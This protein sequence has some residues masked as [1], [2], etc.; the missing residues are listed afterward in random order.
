[1]SGP[2]LAWAVETLIASALLMAAVLLARGPARRAFGPQVA[3][4]LWALPALR[5]LLPP[6][7]SEVAEQV[8]MPIS[9]ASELMLVLPT[10]VPGEAAPADIPWAAIALAFWA[11]GAGAFFVLHL[12]RHRAFCRR[13]LAD[14]RVLDEVDGVRVIESD[15]ASGPLAFGMRRRFVAFPRDFAERYDAEE[16]ELALLHE[17]GH[18]QRRDL[19]ANWAA[20]AVLALHWFNP[21]AWRAFRAFRCDQE[22]A[23]DARV[24]AGRGRADRHI[25]ACAIVKAAHGGHV[26][27]ACHLH[28]IADLKGRLRM[29]T[30]ATP[31]RRRLAAGATAVVGV[32]AAGLCV[33]ASGTRAAAAVTERIGDAVGV[34]LAQVAPAVPAAPVVPTPPVAPSVVTAPRTG[35]AK[36]IHRVVVSKDGETHVYE[37]DD[38]KKYLA[39]NPLPQPPIPP[40][41]VAGAAR[42]AAATPPMPPMP[43]TFR[44]VGPTR[45]RVA[46]DGRTWRSIAPGPDGT[47]RIT[48]P[49]IIN[50]PCDDG[51][52]GDAQSLVLQREL[53]GRKVTIVCQNRVDRAARDGARRGQE[54]AAD[55]RFRGDVARLAARDA[56]HDAQLSIQAARSAILADRNLSGSQRRDALAGLNQ[57]QAELRSSKD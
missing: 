33:T 40:V 39:A 49:E 20:L 56:R 12:L 10:A 5:L 19:W 2:T 44:M 34:D 9:R 53:N 45:L 8:E 15:A 31:S 28:T 41:I 4:A 21:L 25:Y 32:V 46:E 6:L 43:S 37:G 38:A 27:A 1:M 23:N 57:A 54:I 36:S 50:R 30:R 47:I 55:A 48:T 18:H 35:G 11:V 13:L 7:P 29:L 22:L 42:A 52:D 16:R 17:L 3:Y 14:A 51:I 24:L 26:S